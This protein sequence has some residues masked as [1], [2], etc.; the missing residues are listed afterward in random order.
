MTLSSVKL[1]N[2]WGKARSRGACNSNKNSK[3]STNNKTYKGPRGS[4]SL[5]KGPKPTR[6]R[7][8]SLL[9]ELTCKLKAGGK[10]AVGVLNTATGM[11]IL[12]M[13]TG[14]MCTPGEWCIQVKA[15]RLNPN[16]G[17][18]VVQTSESLMNAKDRRAVKSIEGEA[19]TDYPDEIPEVKNDRGPKPKYGRR[20]KLLAP[21]NTWGMNP[22]N[23]Y[24]QMKYQMLINTV[25]SMVHYQNAKGEEVKCTPAEYCLRVKTETKNPNREIK[26]DVNGETLRVSRLRNACLRSKENMMTITLARIYSL[27]W[28]PN[29]R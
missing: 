25:T 24:K 9:T 6:G 1:E 20:L 26:M 27:K 18:K 3:Y 13:K 14:K 12:D 11:I 19:N 22:L 2:H 17:C 7:Q 21:A 10:D 4:H 23:K 8:L 15:A 29:R 16:K 5:E 28:A